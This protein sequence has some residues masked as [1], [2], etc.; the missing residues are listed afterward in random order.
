MALD[1]TYQCAGWCKNVCG[2]QWL[3]FVEDSLKNRQHF[4][5]AFV[6]FHFWRL[7]LRVT[8]NKMGAIAIIMAF[9]NKLDSCESPLKLLFG[10]HAALL[11]TI[12]RS[13]VWWP[14]WRLRRRLIGVKLNT[15]QLVNARA[16]D[17]DIGCCEKTLW[18]VTKCQ[19]NETCTVHVTA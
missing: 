3:V 15:K 14:K 11:P 7:T 2:V 16:W 9:Q 12:E 8:W 1:F 17:D 18:T 6:C 5:K 13:V 4:T 19:E 10:R